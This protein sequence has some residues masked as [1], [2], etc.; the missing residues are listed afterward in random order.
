MKILNWVQ[1]KLNGR[2]RDR[3]STTTSTT[4]YKIQEARQEEFSDWPNGLLA[5]GT[6]GNNQL[7][8][9]SDI[10]DQSTDNSLP[11]ED[12]SDFTAEEVGKLQKQL[13]KLLSLKPVSIVVESGGEKDNLPLDKFLNCPTSLEVDRTDCLRFCDDLN[14]NDGSCSRSTSFI[15]SKGKEVCIDNSSAIRQ[16][17]LS[18]LLKKMFVCHGGFAPAPSISLRDQIPESRM[19]KLLRAI[20]H[21]KVYPQSS[22]STS[23]KKYLG[24]KQTTKID[25]QDQTQERTND[26]CKWVKTD[27][28]FIVLEI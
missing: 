9:E 14:D 1:N 6:F 25:T 2:Q 12:L 15:L 11:S 16:R 28:D 24:S 5:I 26:G 13:T 10:H 18:F 22:A 17:S 4:G 19:E 7:K 23:T 27:S 21:K 8:E 3:K 20:L